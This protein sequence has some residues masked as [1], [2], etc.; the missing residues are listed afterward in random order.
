MYQVQTQ[1]NKFLGSRN[2]FFPINVKNIESIS[3]EK[4]IMPRDYYI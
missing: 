2:M 1:T 3:V 4:L